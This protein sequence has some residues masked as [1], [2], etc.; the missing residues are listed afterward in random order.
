MNFTE[1]PVTCDGAT[2]KNFI[3]ERQRPQ[4]EEKEETIAEE[5]HVK[6]SGFVHELCQQL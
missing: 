2:T 4:E 6:Q 5:T 3:E 1:F